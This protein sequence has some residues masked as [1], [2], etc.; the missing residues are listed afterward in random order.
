VKG[1]GEVFPVLNY[2]PRHE[3]VLRSGGIA[4]RV[5]DF[6]TRWRWVVSFT[7]RPL[8]LRE[9]LRYSL[10]RR[11]GEPE[12][13]SGKIPSLCRESNPGRPGPNAVC[14]KLNG[15]ELCL[16]VKD[17]LMVK[18]GVRVRVVKCVQNAHDR[19]HL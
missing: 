18:T 9:C 7:P 14:Y 16:R 1:K 4:P 12:S 17:C 13:R 6:G 5:L 8:Y 3:D 19:C 15:Y 10:D 2:E 11:L